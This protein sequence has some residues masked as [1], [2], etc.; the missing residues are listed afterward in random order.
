MLSEA[1]TRRPLMDTY[2]SFVPLRSLVPK[3]NPFA[4]AWAEGRGVA[5]FSFKNQDQRSK[6]ETA[7]KKGAK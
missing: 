6:M 7:E 5:T 1:F 3:Y 4:L 2:L